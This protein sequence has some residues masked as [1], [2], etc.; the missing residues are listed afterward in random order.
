M[1]KKNDWPSGPGV[2]QY[3]ICRIPKTNNFKRPLLSRKLGWKIKSVHRTN[4]F[5][6]APINANPPNNQTTSNMTISLILQ[7]VTLNAAWVHSFTRPLVIHLSSTS[8]WTFC[9]MRPAVSEI[10]SQPVP[11]EYDV[12]DVLNPCSYSSSLV[13]CLKALVPATHC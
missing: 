5:R 6:E 13:L 11:V 9:Q 2:E 12:F 1:E 4:C 3:K 10:G 7:L 8:S